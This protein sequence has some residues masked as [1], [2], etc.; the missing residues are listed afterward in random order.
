MTNDL[1]IPLKR[2][3]RRTPPITIPSVRSFC[4]V[5]NKP[6][7]QVDLQG[8]HTFIKLF[9]ELNPKELIQHRAVGSFYETIGS[10][11]AYFG[12]TMLDF[13]QCQ[14]HFKRMLRRATEFRSIICEHCMNL[15]P[16]LSIKRKDVVVQDSRCTFGL[17]PVV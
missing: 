1:K 11:S 17:F 5:M 8:F 4:V 2:L 10:R 14:I 6:F 3:Q 7:I 15:Q 12:T 13:I 9:S 16:S